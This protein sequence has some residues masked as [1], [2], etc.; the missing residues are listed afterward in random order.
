MPTDPW[1]ARGSPASADLQP[2]PEKAT[3]ISER[4][5][6]QCRQPTGFYPEVKP[7]GSRTLSRAVQSALR[8]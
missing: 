7:K 2:K 8:G 4:G 1:P 3:L 6:Y 5:L